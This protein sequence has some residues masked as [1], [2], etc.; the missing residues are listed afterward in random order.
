MN[1]QA[2]MPPTCSSCSSSLAEFMLP[3]PQRLPHPLKW[4]LAAMLH[5]PAMTLVVFFLK[6]TFDKDKDELGLALTT[7][8][9]KKSD[10]NYAICID[11]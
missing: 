6:K 10:E 3:P 1:H 8:C 9:P 7:M 2:K 4:D 11:Y 5:S